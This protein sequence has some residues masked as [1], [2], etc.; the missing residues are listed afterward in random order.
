MNNAPLCVRRTSANIIAAVIYFTRARGLY[1]FWISYRWI[2][3]HLCLVLEMSLLCCCCRV[4]FCI[5]SSSLSLFSQEYQ[6]SSVLG[7]FVTRFMLRETSGQLLS[8]Q[9]SL[10]CAMEAVGEQSSP[11]PLV[12]GNMTPSEPCVTS[13]DC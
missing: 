3:F 1:L 4:W 13:A 11:A 2:S 8:L 12:Y 10:Q 7:Q 5:I 6:G 9:R